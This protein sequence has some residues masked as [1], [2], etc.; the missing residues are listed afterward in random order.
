MEKVALTPERIECLRLWYADPE[1]NIVC[2]L[3][4]DGLKYREWATQDLEA[5]DAEVRRKALLE[6][7][8]VASRVSC[9]YDK[10]DGFPSH[11]AVGAETVAVTLRKKAEERKE[12]Q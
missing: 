3:A 5:H 6:A 9:S 1:V 8:E 12:D 7:A 2:D 11:H 10:A 4:L